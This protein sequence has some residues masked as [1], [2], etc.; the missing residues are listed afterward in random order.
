[1]ILLTQILV[2][3]DFSDASDAAL[4]HGR[5]LARTHGASLHLLHVMENQF[6][7]PSPADPS[8]LK[9]GAARNLNERLTDDDRAALHA[10]AAL[11]TSDSPAETI[12]KYAGEHQIGLI[13]MGTHGRGPVEQL[14]MGSVAETVVRRAPCPVLTVKQP[15]DRRSAMIT[16]RNIL[17]ATDFSEPS[18]AA[19]TYGR[20]LARSFKA[21]LH[22]VH[23]V[24]NVSSAVYGV[25]GYT[26][27]MPELQQEVEDRARQQ[28]D[29]LLVDN[30]QPPLPTR[31]VLLTSNAPAMAIVDYAGR[32]PIDLIVTGT[33]GRGAVAHLLMGSVAERVVRT[34]PCPVLT[35][36]H[37]EHEF[38]VP[39]ALVAAAKA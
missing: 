18:D 7:R 17:V 26:A 27:T 38:V 25:D 14:L 11:E 2:A 1:M 21:A 5:A 9:A 37:P 23:V 16:L 3:T 10:H 12:V 36:R 19:L 33:H 30:D 8:L 31:R 32:E 13:V 29:E 28:L 24:A 15:V 39:D 35:V 34:A 6:L 22:V 4:V 20:A